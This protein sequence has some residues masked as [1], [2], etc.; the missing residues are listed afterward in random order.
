MKSAPVSLFGGVAPAVS[1]ALG[2]SSYHTRTSWKRFAAK[3]PTAEMGDK[4][5][6]RLFAVVAKNFKAVLTNRDRVTSVQNWRVRVP[7]VHTSPNNKSLEVLAERWLVCSCL[8]L[9]RQDWWN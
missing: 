8:K 6:E 2:V 3:P 7:N 1:E 9:G 4:L 5:A